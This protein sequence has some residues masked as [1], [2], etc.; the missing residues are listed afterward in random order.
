MFIWGGIMHK[1]TGLSPKDFEVQIIEKQF[2]KNIK[3]VFDVFYFKK[4]K[5]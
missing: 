3:K 5:L 2:I 4:V 1:K